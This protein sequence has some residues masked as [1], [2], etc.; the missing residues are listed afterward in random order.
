MLR[1]NQLKSTGFGSG[2]RLA[3]L[4]NARHVEFNSIQSPLEK[5]LLNIVEEMAIAAGLQPP[6]IYLLG[7]MSIN[8]F[9]A[10]DSL[11]HSVIVLTH[12]AV[13][14][15][16]RHELQSVVG[17]E[18][19]H[20]LN[21]DIQINTRLIIILGGF[22]FLAQF[23]RNFLRSRAAIIG[24]AVMIVGS[25]GYLFGKIF[26][27]AISRQREHLA[28][29]ASVQFTRNPIGLATALFRIHKF[30]KKSF[31]TTPYRDDISH[32]CFGEI[33]AFNGFGLFSTHPPI[34]DRIKK[35]FPSFSGTLLLPKPDGMM[36]NEPHE[37]YNARNSTNIHSET[38]H[39]FTL[40]PKVEER[41]DLKT[42]T[43]SAE[44]IGNLNFSS[45]EH[46]HTILTN[47]SQSLNKIAHDISQAPLLLYAY[48]IQASE[49]SS[50]ALEWIQH[51]I[52]QEVFDSCKKIYKLLPDP[53]YERIILIEIAIATLH[54]ANELMRTEIITKCQQI[55]LLDREFNLFDWVLIS[56]LHK[57]L[58]YRKDPDIKPRTLNFQSV[59]PFIDTL[60]R[61]LLHRQK[62]TATEQ[63]TLYRALRS[64]MGYKNSNEYFS[65]EIS[66]KSLRSCLLQLAALPVLLKYEIM[67]LVGDCLTIDKNVSFEEWEI[68]RAIGD[69]LDC[70]IPVD[71][72]SNIELT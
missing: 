43:K 32:A 67:V 36:R 13:N 54:S 38:E 15:L 30:P 1:W 23:G 2:H 12:G 7:D 9:A 18:F 48:L 37:N 26:Q 40:V 35:I 72:L 4:L 60:I 19:S 39:S 41:N 62:I 33:R 53:N 28:D 56:L 51:N 11:D 57:R 16:T 49:D 31:L 3:Q 47:L 8:A 61:A 22:L 34:K 63:Q 44:I 64:Q 69:I 24:L 58:N 29:A 50:R 66:V 46:A 65:K 68:I 17:H 71:F 45:V 14:E 20:I 21:G 5:R 25:V 59:E 6:A 42:F 55:G 10:G 27:A 52:S 70:P